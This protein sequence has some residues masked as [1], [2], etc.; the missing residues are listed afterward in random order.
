[1]RAILAKDWC[2]VKVCCDHHLQLK[3]SAA[4]MHISSFFLPWGRTLYN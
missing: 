1:M 2:W 3:I 4:F